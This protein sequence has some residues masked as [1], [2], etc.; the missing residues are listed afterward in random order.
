MPNERT[1]S[2]LT[3]TVSTDNVGLYNYSTEYKQKEMRRWK[4]NSEASKGLNFVIR[5]DKKTGIIIL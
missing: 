4:E 5:E 3:G 1:G 2:R